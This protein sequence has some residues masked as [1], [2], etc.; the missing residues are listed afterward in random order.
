MIEFLKNYLAD[1]QIPVGALTKGGEIFSRRRVEVP[2]RARSR[3]LDPRQKAEGFLN[4][5]FRK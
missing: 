5:V 4:F 2:G 1:L 3:V